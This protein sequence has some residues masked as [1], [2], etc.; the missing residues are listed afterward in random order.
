MNEKFRAKSWIFLG[1][2][3]CIVLISCQIGSMNPSSLTASGKETSMAASIN[4]TLTANAEIAASNV[5]PTDPPPTNTAIPS[6]TP[7]PQ[8]SATPEPSATPPPSATERPTITEVLATD[9]P[10][11][12]NVTVKNYMNVTINLTLSGPAFKAFSVAAHGSYTFQIQ[13]GHY[14]WTFKANNFY[15]D[16][17]YI[18]ITGGDFL[19]TWGKA[20]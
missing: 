9:T 2:L 19:W 16:S 18:D 14:A 3:I 11:I 4:A 1:S 7:T 12:S 8:P 6:E 5:P 13:P 20:K 10:E 15:P 17:G